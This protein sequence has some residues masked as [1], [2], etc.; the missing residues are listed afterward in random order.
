MAIWFGDWI[1]GRKGLDG[2]SAI[3]HRG[4]EETAGTVFAQHVTEYACPDAPDEVC[5]DFG[6]PVVWT[7]PL[8]PAH[9]DDVAFDARIGA[10]M[11]T[12]P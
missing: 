11:A 9:P 6:A 10:E 2:D 12:A 8:P 1:N 3:L 7:G 4:V 5:F